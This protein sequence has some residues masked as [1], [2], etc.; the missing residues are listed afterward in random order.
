MY[1]LC[2]GCWALQCSMSTLSQSKRNF[3]RSNDRQMRSYHFWKKYCL[4]Y[5]TLAPASLPCRVHLLLPK[6]N[7]T[8]LRIIGRCETRGADHRRITLFGAKRVRLAGR[9]STKAHPTTTRSEAKCICLCIVPAISTDDR[10]DSKSEHKQTH[11]H[12]DILIQWIL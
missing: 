6:R 7:T 12:H 9:I 1:S 2:A 3:R 8:S 5:Y 4:L 11:T 10:W